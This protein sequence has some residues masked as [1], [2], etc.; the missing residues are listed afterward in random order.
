MITWLFDRRNRWGFIPNLV[1]RTDI[2]PGSQEWWNLALIPPYSEEFR[3]LRYCGMEGVKV[4]A[5]LLHDEIW[6]GPAYYP[7]KLN[8]WAPEL[9]YFDYMPKESLHKLQQ[10]LFKVLFYYD[11]GDDPT[12]DLLPHL[13]DMCKRNNINI[14]QIRVATA[15]WNLDGQAPFVFIA[16]DELYYRY[17][18]LVRR[19][20]EWVQEVNLNPREKILTCLTRADKV[21]RRVFG[22]QFVD[23]GLH[24]DSYYSYNNFKYEMYHV[25][26]DKLALWEKSIPKL[27]EKM[28]SFSLQLPFKA[29]DLTD[30]EHNS[31]SI[32]NKQ[33][34]DNAYW[35]IVVETHFDQHTT[36]LTEKTFKPILNMQPFVVC[37]N[38]KSLKLLKHLGYKTF[39]TV[40]NEDYDNITDHQQ[41]MTA[42]LKSAYTIYHTTEKQHINIMR[43][44]KPVL[45]YNQRHFLAP[46]AGRIRNFLSQL[47]Y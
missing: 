2:K 22:S 1:S 47:E 8:Y 11:E 14:N 6:S 24:I 40:L 10:G 20:Q 5:R 41:R 3:F 38:P 35:Q 18:H 36:F 16:D 37:G 27:Q 13:H 19:Q 33:H 44:L 45:E 29:D 32:I 25:D 46:K 23:L 30:A 17:L 9:D 7:I 21:W 31:H 4:Q 26:D 43:N 28:S 42:V 15:N 12:V 34:H 39:S